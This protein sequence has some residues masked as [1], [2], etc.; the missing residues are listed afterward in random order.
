MGSTLQGWP[1]AVRLPVATALATAGLAVLLLPAALVG[2]DLAGAPVVP[3][4]VPPAVALVALVCSPL[5]SLGTR[6]IRRLWHTVALFGASTLVF[7]FGT[8]ALA[9]SVGLAV[10]TPAKRAVL[11][12]LAYWSTFLAR[13][14]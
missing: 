5:Y 7:V 10:E 9:P 11:W 1:A 14:L 2:N 6:S 3:A 13:H 12:V 4:V 8:E